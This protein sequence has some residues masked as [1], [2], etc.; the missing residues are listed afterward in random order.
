MSHLNKE[1]HLLVV[2]AVEAELLHLF[3]ETREAVVSQ[4][5]GRKTVSG[6]IGGQR[7]KIVATGPGIVNTVQALTAC[8]EKERPAMVIQ[9]GCAGGFREAGITI[10]DVAVA[11]EEVDI[12]AGIEPSEGHNPFPLVPL[13][14]PLLSQGGK[15]IKNRYGL[16]RRLAE[17]FLKITEDSKLF[18]GV[19][20]FKGPFVT[21][22]TITATDKRAGQLF[23]AYQP[24][25]E[26]ME[27]SAA[28]HTTML[29]DIPFMEVRAAS[30]FTGKR[31]R[32]SWN[33]DLA[34][35][36]CGLAVVEFIRN[37]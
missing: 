15:E 8:I 4:S 35:E 33:L 32:D 10:G 17:T 12:H 24:V 37:H 11:T 34:F 1:R 13:P 28:A 27:G 26:S 29:Y 14:F 2:A 19:G 7:V 36:R 16:D 5:H 30:N 31:D 6:M 21:G 18:K 22:S 3:R 23:Q 20:L 9:T 25:M